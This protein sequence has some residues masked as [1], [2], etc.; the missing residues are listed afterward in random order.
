M[1]INKL[2]S[3]YKKTRVPKMDVSVNEVINMED[4]FQKIKIQD[5]DDEK[6]M[7]HNQIIP[8][9]VGLFLITVVIL[10]NP[11]K[12]FLLLT[13]MFLVFTGLI[14]SLILKF[15]DYKDISKESYDL[16][17][18]AYLKQKEERLKSWHSTPRKYKWTYTVFVSGLVFMVIGNTSLMRDFDTEYIILFIAIYLGLLVTFWII[19]EKFYHKRHKLKHQPLIKGITEL[20]E[21]LSEE[22][23]ST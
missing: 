8:L 4:F 18:L 22:K 11:I 12:T 16:S 15:M 14:Y 1:D 6:Y 3:E 21:E 13:G 7:L 23:I 10:I 20:L 19:G 17:L 2:K 9:I 5:K